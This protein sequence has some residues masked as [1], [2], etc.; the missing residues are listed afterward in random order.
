MSGWTFAHKTLTKHISGLKDDISLLRI[1]AKHDK[2]D[3]DKQ[4]ALLQNRI[5][6]VE[7]R[8]YQGLERQ[9]GQ[10]HNSALHLI[11]NGRIEPPLGEEK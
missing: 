8:G 1:E 11:R 4:L 10:V 6:E 7:D 2:D 9:L 3:C 5:K